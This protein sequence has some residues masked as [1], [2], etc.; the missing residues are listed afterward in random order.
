MKR[1]A[2]S[3]W[4]WLFIAP[5]FFSL[6]IVV[7]VPFIT[8]IGYS[9]T[10]WDG[11]NKAV[12]CGI[13]NYKSV[14]G[15]MEFFSSLWFTAKVSIVAVIGTN[16]LGLGLALLVTQPWRERNLL[17]VCYFSPNLI[18]G[19][20]LGFIWQFIFVSIFPEIGLNGWLATS[21]TGFWGLCILYIW[22][23]AGYNM[24]I[25]VAFLEAIPT[26]MQE[27]ATLDGSNYW[28]RFRYITLPMLA[29]AFTICM[30]ITL[31][32]SFKLY[33]Q[34]LALTE[35][36]PFR[37]TEMLAMNI[38]NTAFSL[39]N[40]GLAQVKAVIFFLLVASITL[41]QTYFSKKREVEV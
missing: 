16:V 26:D 28:Q 35:G 19:L 18:G 40:M 6:V 11:I 4:F 1:N 9:F 13:E 14:L 22:Q 2:N 37:S 5:A 15:D 8:G 21:K 27:A 3:L 36:G 32:N 7:F 23:K 34:N 10:N 12:N 29:P 41:L 24:V 39:R 31:S 17:R 25:F 38:Y 20:I 33:D 30:F